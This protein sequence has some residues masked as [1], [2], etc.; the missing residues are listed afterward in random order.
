MNL[1]KRVICESFTCY[2]NIKINYRRNYYNE[3]AKEHLIKSIQLLQKATSLLESLSL[4]IKL[5]VVDRNYKI[6][7]EVWTLY[8]V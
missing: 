8:N 7:G 3:Y 1:E 4:F 6:N 5:F 2:N